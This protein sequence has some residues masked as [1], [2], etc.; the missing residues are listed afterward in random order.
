[1]TTFRY[2]ALDQAGQEREGTAKGRTVTEVRYSLQ[3]KELMLTEISV[4]KS[5]LDIQVTQPRVTPTELMH[6]SHQ[7]AAFIR[8]GIPL[9]DAITELGEGADSR[10]VRQVMT[11]IAADLR[12]GSS[13]TEAFDRHPKDF[14][15]F[16]RGILKSAELTGQLDVVL[17]QLATY[18]ERDMEARRKIKSAMVY[19]AVVAV[20]AVGTVVI[21]TFFVLPKFEVFF[22]NLDAQLPLPT[23]MLLVFSAF[24]Q[25][26]W[27]VIAGLILLVT[28]IY[29]LGVRTP[30]GR[31][32]R[33]RTLLRVPAVGDTLRASLIER[34]ARILASMV[35]AGVPLPEAMTVA[36]NSLNN[37][38]FELPLQ[39]ARS[40]MLDGAGLTEPIAATR[41]FP[42]M[43]IQMLRVGE[44]TGSLDTQLEVAAGFYARELDYK[45]KRLATLVEPAVI[46]V[47]GT[48]VGFVAIALV[49]AMYGI[50]RST[51]LV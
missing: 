28:L 48:I 42:S 26:W 15:T 32:L 2:K 46:V 21:L 23:R 22:A 40:A 5:A 36:T 20:M 34:F 30:R 49:S 18:L 33:D 1:M 3:S 8:A 44:E 9:L 17:D 41:L 51:S 43:A 50:F 6:L 25:S 45:V 12:S 10:A 14:P 39:Q 47:M 38:A 37:L 16:Y 19:P 27:P 4:K 13:L 29:V 7:L 35:G 31:L 11:D 24:V